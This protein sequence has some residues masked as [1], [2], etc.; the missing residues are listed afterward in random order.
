M[1]IPESA[2]EHSIRPV[3]F[4][5]RLFVVWAECIHQDQSASS[6]PSKADAMAPRVNHP[7]LRLSYCFKKQDG[8]WSTPRVGLQGYCEDKNA[9]QPEPGGDQAVD[10]FRCDAAPQGLARLTV[11][12]LMCTKAQSRLGVRAGQCLQ[13][14]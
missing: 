6:A 5:N 8:M 3:W 11:S 7:L 12:G 13:F 2:V 9:C 1:P 10:R 4:N 14:Y